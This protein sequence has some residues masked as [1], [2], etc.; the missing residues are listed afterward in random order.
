M[1][2]CVCVGGGCLC[3]GVGVGVSVWVG[4][5]VGGWVSVSVSVCKGG[6]GVARMGVGGCV[7]C[8]PLSIGKQEAGIIVQVGMGGGV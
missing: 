4:G 5:W 1:Y 3:V 7:R 8:S 6:G 2:V